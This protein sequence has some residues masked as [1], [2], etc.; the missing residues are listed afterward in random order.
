[1]LSMRLVVQ[2]QMGAPVFTQWNQLAG[3][4]FPAKVPSTGA[5]VCRLPRL[6]LPASAYRIGY[7]LATAHRAGE[8]LDLMHHAFDLQVEKGDFFGSGDTPLIQ[9]GVAL[10]PA[11]WR[12]EPDV[13][14]RG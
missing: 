7:R 2:T 9:N 6:P 3:H 1:M 12:M 8:V 14:P 4:S 11:E 5:F 10:V 13:T